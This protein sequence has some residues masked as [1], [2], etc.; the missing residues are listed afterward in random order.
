MFL[1]TAMSN[2]LSLAFTAVFLYIIYH[3]VDWALVKWWHCIGDSCKREN[4]FNP[5]L[6][7]EYRDKNHSSID[8]Y[9]TMCES[10]KECQCKK[11]N[12][13]REHIYKFLKIIRASINKLTIHGIK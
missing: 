11:R 6:E 5:Q 13:Y 10:S 3:I 1:I 9:K 7:A 8:F 12:F 4:C 2:A